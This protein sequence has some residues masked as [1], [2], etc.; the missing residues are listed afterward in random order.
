MNSGSCKKVKK[1]RREKAAAL[2]ES[3]LH[4]RV[5]GSQRVSGPFW[6][7]G[8]VAVFGFVFVRTCFGPR[9]WAPDISNPWLC[10]P[11]ATAF[12]RV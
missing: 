2:L 12:C 8:W 3:V 9:C 7:C 6:S 4:L 1:F 10:L 11:G 5:H